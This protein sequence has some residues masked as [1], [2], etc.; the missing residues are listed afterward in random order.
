MVTTLIMAAL[1]TYQGTEGPAFNTVTFWYVQ[2]N[3]A[4]LN[5]HSF[6]WAL[7]VHEPSVWLNSSKCHDEIAKRMAKAPGC[8]VRVEG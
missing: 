7:V 4:I 3:I 8:T 5:W 2:S 6:L 1:S